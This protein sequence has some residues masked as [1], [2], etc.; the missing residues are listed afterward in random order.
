MTTNKVLWFLWANPVFTASSRIQGLAIHNHL[1]KCGYASGIAYIPTSFERTIPFSPAIEKSLRTL[2]SPGDIV[3]LQKCKDKVNLPAIHFFK[4]IGVKMVLID[5]DLPIEIDIG[6]AVDHVICSSHL[7]SGAYSK[8]DIKSTFI[9]DAPERF[10]ERTFFADKK[11]FTCVWF[12]DG[13][14]NRWNDVE[15]L[16]TILQDSRL[17][18]WELITISNH[19]DA[20]VQWRP[21]YLTTMSTQA[22]VV[23][24]PVFNQDDLGVTKSANRLLQS[25]AL[26]LPI[27][28]SPIHSYQAI[29][30]V[31]KGIIVCST[32][33]DWINAFLLLEN[34]A[35]RK[36]YSTRAFLGSQKY[37]LENRI[38]QWKDAL[39]LDES[40]KNNHRSED[41]LKQISILFYLELVKKNIRYV[42][43]VPFSWNSLQ[44]AIH[45]LIFRFSRTFS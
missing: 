43:R 3:I 1:I 33:E 26:S 28:C 9:E 15:K 4:S 8:L 13:T 25:M 21:N 34:T 32:G 12:G 37:R 24:L 16:K 10:G 41:A 31:E 11:K 35:I 20:T 44:S 19:A 18:N 30:N 40:F 5:C 27:L 7:L 38:T 6:K 29:A 2:L 39:Q 45:Y 36:E 17:S 14:G 23:A 42:T 22:D